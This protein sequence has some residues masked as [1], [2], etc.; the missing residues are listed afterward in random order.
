MC[1]FKLITTGTLYGS[2]GDIHWYELISLQIYNDS[3]KGFIIL[4]AA[5]RFHQFREQMSYE[6]RIFYYLDEGGIL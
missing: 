2:I 1:R 4:S 6:Y 3:P 5:I